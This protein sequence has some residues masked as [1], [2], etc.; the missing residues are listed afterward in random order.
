MRDQDR[1]AGVIG[2]AG[3]LRQIRDEATGLLLATY[4]SPVV[5]VLLA[6]VPLDVQRS[7]CNDPHF[8]GNLDDGWH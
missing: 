2:I 8:S 5:G 6:V 4:A 3:T 1:V 7:A